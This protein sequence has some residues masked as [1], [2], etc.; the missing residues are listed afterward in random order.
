MKSK[1][2]SSF[3]SLKTALWGFLM[4]FSTIGVIGHLVIHFVQKEDSMQ[5]IIFFGVL[6]LLS[7]YRFIVNY[8][9]YKSPEFQ[10]LMK[11]SQQ[12]W[13]DYQKEKKIERANKS[14]STVGTVSEKPTN[15]GNIIFWIFASIGLAIYTV[16]GTIFKVADN[17]SPIFPTARR[18]GRRRRRGRRKY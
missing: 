8:R 16:L 17:V 13:I 10:R 18:G 7:L 4:F 9:I 12:Q 2:V 11:Q 14:T 6:F 5:V 3:T 15:N 1:K